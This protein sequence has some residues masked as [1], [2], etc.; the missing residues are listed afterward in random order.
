MLVAAE[1][2]L[3]KY[4]YLCKNCLMVLYKCRFIFLAPDDS[5]AGIASAQN[6][7]T[8]HS[9]FDRL[10]F[11]QLFLFSPLSGTLISRTFLGECFYPLLLPCNCCLWLTRIFASGCPNWI[12]FLIYALHRLIHQYFFCTRCR[13]IKL[14]LGKFING[15]PIMRPFCFYT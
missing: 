12:F 3:Y 13:K 10:I 8:R 9:K 2:I 1:C 6:N 14:S 11:S 4:I 5:G 15:L 7:V